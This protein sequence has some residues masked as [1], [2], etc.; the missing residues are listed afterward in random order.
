MP[1]IWYTLAVIFKL[2]LPSC[3]AF[4]IHI[5]CESFEFQLATKSLSSSLPIWPEY[6]SQDIKVLSSMRKYFSSLCHLSIRK[7]W[8]MQINFYS[9]PN[10][11]RTIRVNK[12]PNWHAPLTGSYSYSF[13]R[14]GIFQLIWSIL[15]VLVP[16]LLKSPGHQQVWHWLYRRDNM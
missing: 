6:S 1:P 13:A 4:Q 8:N 9:L 3:Q 11:F 16:W 5:S 2:V 12:L 14:D 15:C 10:R 7:W